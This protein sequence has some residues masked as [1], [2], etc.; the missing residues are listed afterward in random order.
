M[1]P[2][3][4][5]KG[6]YSKT[7]P[8]NWLNQTSKGRLDPRRTPLAHGGLTRRADVRMKGPCMETND[9]PSIGTIIPRIAHLLKK[10]GLNP[11]GASE[12]GLL[13]RYVNAGRTAELLETESPKQFNGQ[14]VDEHG[15]E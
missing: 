9:P 4:K 1:R 5:N 6:A 2:W 7:R 14:F 8:A 10:Q 3:K 15:A 11:D 12:P 13:L